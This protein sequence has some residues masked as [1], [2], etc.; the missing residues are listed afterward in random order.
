MEAAV[1]HLRHLRQTDRMMV[2]TISGKLEVYRRAR[3]GCL[4]CWRACVDQFVCMRGH[5]DKNVN[6]HAHAHVH[7]H[8]LVCLCLCLFSCLCLFVCVCV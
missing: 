8:V 5:V 1:R 7:V 3:S 2:T 4:C 6:A